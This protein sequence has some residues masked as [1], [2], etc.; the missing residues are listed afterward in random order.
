[1]SQLRSQTGFEALCNPFC[2]ACDKF[3]MHS[4]QALCVS[5][6]QDSEVHGSTAWTLFDK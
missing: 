6:L 1:M 4:W 3:S 2:A 5:I